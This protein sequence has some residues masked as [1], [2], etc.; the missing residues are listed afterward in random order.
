MVGVN[1]VG[2]LHNSNSNN[3]S[4]TSKVVVE[5]HSKAVGVVGA[6]AS[7]HGGIWMKCYASRLVL[8]YCLSFSHVDQYIST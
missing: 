4:R 5:V 7:N 1:M 6:E 3:L 8:D 2:V